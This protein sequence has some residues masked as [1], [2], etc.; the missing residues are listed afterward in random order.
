[1][2]DGRSLA[3]GVRVRS[4]RAA[5]GPRGLGEGGVTQPKSWVSTVKLTG[6]TEA[7]NLRRS[8]KRMERHTPIAH[9][10]EV[11]YKRTCFSRLCR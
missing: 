8:S 4:V 7:V 10:L 3:V 1:M 6:K 2:K 9:Y 11:A 5:G